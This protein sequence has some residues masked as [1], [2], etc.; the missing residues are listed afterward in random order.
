MHGGPLKSNAIS[1]TRPTWRAILARM[2]PRSVAEHLRELR[3]LSGAER[4][5]HVSM[6][7]RR[8][9]T[10]RVSVPPGLTADSS[11]LFVCHGNIIRSALAEALYRRHAASLWSAPTRVRSAGL[12][13]KAGRG[14]DAR[15][16]AAG[17]SLGVDLESHH[18][19]PLTAALADDADV[20]F[21]MDRLNEAKLIARFP[22]AR[23]KVR[24]LGA[25]STAG[26]S[27]VIADPYAHDGAAVVAA[28]EQIDR[29]TAVLAALVNETRR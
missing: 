22:N 20:I 12:S 16:V 8:L 10:R 9:V 4:G 6:T 21:V 26:G 27:D 3:T 25:W 29:A 5:A 1:V 19:Q 7:L 11:V 24:R 14:A 17:R 18:A 2:L 13:A 28:A 15:A 23:G